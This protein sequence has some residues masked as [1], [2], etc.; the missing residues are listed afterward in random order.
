MH[1][2][3]DRE[4]KT[5]RGSR[6]EAGKHRYNNNNVLSVNIPKTFNMGSRLTIIFFKNP[7]WSVRFSTNSTWVV[8]FQLSV[9]PTWSVYFQLSSSKIQYGRF[10]FN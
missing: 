2:I 5:G 9:N 10:T 3:N 1:V 6:G 4:N 8:W 7:I